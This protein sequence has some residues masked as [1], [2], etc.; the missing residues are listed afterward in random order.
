MNR[1]QISDPPFKSWVAAILYILDGK[2]AF[3]RNF[4]LRMPPLHPKRT[5]SVM[6]FTV[7]T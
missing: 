5:F 3:S 1:Q 2:P 7:E 6:P 4:L